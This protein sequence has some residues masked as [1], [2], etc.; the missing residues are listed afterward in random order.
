MSLSPERRRLRAQHAATRRHHP[1]RLELVE[2]QRRDLKVLAAED[3][4]QRLIGSEPSPTPEQRVRLAQVLLG[5]Q[6][7][8]GEVRHVA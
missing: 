3:Y 1:D 8:G 4:I 5:H 7:A 6:D 2:T